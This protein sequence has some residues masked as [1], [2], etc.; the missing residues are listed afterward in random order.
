MSTPGGNVLA[1]VRG[2]RHPNTLRLDPCAPFFFP[3]HLFFYFLYFLG[4]S[5]LHREAFKD[6]HHIGIRVQLFSGE[7][8]SR[9]AATI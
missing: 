7:E 1:K 8:A 4:C 3:L 9:V 2:A 5:G 6:T